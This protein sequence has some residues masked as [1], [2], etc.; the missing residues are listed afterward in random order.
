VKIL[1]GL[2][3]LILAVELSG[4]GTTQQANN[5]WRNPKASKHAPYKSVFVVAI[6]RD[7][8]ARA[9]M[10]KDLALAVEDLGLK[11][12]K[13]VDVFPVAFT[14]ETA[15]AKEVMLAKIR[16]LKCDAI[17]T[18]SPWDIK[19]QER[20]V[21]GAS[22]YSPSASTYY[23]TGGFSGYYGY[24]YPI[25]VDPGHFTTT[26]TYFLEGS[27]FDAATEEIQ[28]TMQST[29]YNP[30][31]IESFSKGYAKLLIRELERNN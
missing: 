28:W 9:T 18:V 27:L 10:E 16:E 24:V 22:V 5:F 6:A 2:C 30:Q 12:T 15:P 1:S 3:F 26:T 31:D 23:W 19:N 14:K 8:A 21:V 17:F 29:A 7:P 20:F 25:V 11:A 13:S 4:C